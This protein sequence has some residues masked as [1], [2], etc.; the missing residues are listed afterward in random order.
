MDDIDEILPILEKF[1]YILDERITYV[2]LGGAVY[3]M[4]ENH[5]HS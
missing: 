1:F 3:I 5:V 2:N 4:S